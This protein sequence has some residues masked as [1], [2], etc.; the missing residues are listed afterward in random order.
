MTYKEAW[1]QGSL[2]LKAAEIEEFSL[3]ARILLEFI[4]KTDRTDMLVHPE[5]ELTGDEE[6]AYLGLINKRSKHIPLQHLTG[7]QNFMGLDFK[8]NKDVLIPRQDTETLVE[9]VLTCLHDRMRILDMCTGSGCILLSLLHYSNDCEGVGA[10][11]SPRALLV[12]KENAAQLGIEAEFLESNLFEKV[13]GVFDIIVS[14]P[15]Y[16]VTCEIEELMPEVRDHDPFIA[17]DGKEDGVTFYRRIIADAGKYLKQGG[18]L[19]FEIGC[20]QGKAVSQM[21]T[22]AGYI[23]VNVKKDLCGLDRVVIGRKRID[24]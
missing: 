7:V 6:E 23:D 2:V 4:C 9:E 13:E 22:D 20:E 3:D 16:I 19:A 1:E 14:N 17:L 10:D 8:V 21:M 5:R 11:I 18:V 15:P 24:V 12:A